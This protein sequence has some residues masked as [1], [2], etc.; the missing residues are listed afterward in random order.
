MVRLG[1]VRC[2]LNKHLSFINTLTGLL[3]LATLGQCVFIGNLDSRIFH[4]LYDFKNT[5]MEL[6]LAWST[7]HIDLIIIKFIIIKSMTLHDE[8]MELNAYKQ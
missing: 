8:N 2:C 1:Y 6:N 4:L 3:K 5:L 7:L